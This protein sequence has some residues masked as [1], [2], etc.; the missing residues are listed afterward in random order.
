MYREGLRDMI[1]WMN[2][3]KDKGYFKNLEYIEVSANYIGSV[4][5]TNPDENTVIDINNAIISEFSSFCSDVANVPNLKTINLAANTWTNIYGSY[6]TLATEIKTICSN[7]QGTTVTIDMS[8]LRTNF[9]YICSDTPGYGAESLTYY[10]FDLQK[11]VDQCRYTWNWEPMGLSYGPG[12][13]PRS[14]VVCPTTA[15]P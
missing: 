15:T 5:Q 3:N 2:T 9:P 12:P 6:D 8:T 10:N 13:Y 4:N 1:S 14:S 11:D 7:R